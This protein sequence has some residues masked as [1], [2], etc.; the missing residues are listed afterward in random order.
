M[1]KQ[2]H[3]P[4]ATASWQP[5]SG[6]TP[7]HRARRRRRS[8]S[9][10]VLESPVAARRCPF[11]PLQRLLWRRDWSS[12]AGLDRWWTAPATIRWCRTTSSAPLRHGERPCGVLDLSTAA[13]PAL[14]SQPS[15]RAS[16]HSG[17]ATPGKGTGAALYPLMQQRVLHET[18]KPSQRVLCVAFYLSAFCQQPSAR[19]P[20][21][22]P[23]AGYEAVPLV[24]LSAP[25]SRL[26]GSFAFHNVRSIASCWSG[27]QLAASASNAGDPLRARRGRK[28]PPRP[29]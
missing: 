22:S 23:Y 28:R 14:A 24:H 25:P 15:C 16:C 4:A 8:R 7:R 9:W 11:Y 10:S 17:R 5:C 3:L 6:M 20:S 12:D 26:R 13:V 19:S 21:P 27:L 29:L 1:V 18:V 2:G